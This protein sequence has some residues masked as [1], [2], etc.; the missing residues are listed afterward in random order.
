MIVLPACLIPIAIYTRKIRRASREMQTQL[1][2]LTQIMTETFTGHRIVKAYNL[3]NIIAG[4]I[5]RHHSQSRRQSHA[6]GAGKRNSRR[7]G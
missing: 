2:E 1:A 5:S 3:E 6:H 4:T 7:I